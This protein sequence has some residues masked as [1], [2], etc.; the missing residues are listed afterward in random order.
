[1]RKSTRTENIHLDKYGKS[2]MYLVVHIRYE[3]RIVPRVAVRSKVSKLQCMENV[4]LVG[5]P[6]TRDQKLQADNKARAQ[7]KYKE[8]LPVVPK[9]RIYV[10]LILLTGPPRLRITVA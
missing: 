10:A 3:V 5:V 1:M 7:K 4:S 8:N 2:E 6:I 9:R